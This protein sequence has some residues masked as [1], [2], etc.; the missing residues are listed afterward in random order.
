MERKDC[1][2]IDFC[3]EIFYEPVD[4]EPLHICECHTARPRNI[5]MKSSDAPHRLVLTQPYWV[6]VMPT[7]LC[8]E[9]SSICVEIKRTLMCAAGCRENFF[10]I[11]I[12]W[13]GTGMLL[14]PG[15]YTFNIPQQTAYGF[16]MDQ[17]LCEANGGLITLL[18]EPATEQEIKAGIFN[19][20]YGGCC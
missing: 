20:L 5:Q 1:S 11:P 8:I 14:A 4:C 6:H 17:S 3:M 13:K 16:P 18:L 7:D 12:C 10:S 2:Y 9:F 15:E 19:S